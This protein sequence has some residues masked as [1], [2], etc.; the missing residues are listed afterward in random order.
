MSVDTLVDVAFVL[1][2][3][4]ELKLATFDPGLARALG[5][6]PTAL[7]CALLILT[8]TTAVADFDAVG[9]VLFI[10]FVMVR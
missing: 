6:A 9:A 3:F 8:S 5:F 4:K 7:F 1:L 2:F 10:A